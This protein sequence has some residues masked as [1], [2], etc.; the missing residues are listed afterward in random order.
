MP[1]NKSPGQD[2][3]PVELYKIYWYLFGDDLLDVFKA[4]GDN[5]PLTIDARSRLSKILFA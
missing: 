5:D 3:I 4:L 1:N 2:G